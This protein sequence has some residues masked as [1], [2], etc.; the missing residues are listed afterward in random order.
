MNDVPIPDRPDRPNICVH[1][2]A[3]FRGRIV[4]PERPLPMTPHHPHA[5][6]ARMGVLVTL[7]AVALSVASCG[8]SMTTAPRPGSADRA[9]GGTSSPYPNSTQEYL[10]DVAV[11]PVAGADVHQLAT[12]YGA[13][14]APGSNYTC[15]RLQPPSG[16]SC[17]ELAAQLSAD[18]RVIAAERNGVI[19]TAETRQE[20]Y[21]SDD[22]LGSYETAN[23]QPAAQAVGLDAAHRVSGGDGVLVAVIDTGV[24]PTHPL[25][26]SRLV[27]G[28]DYVDYDNDPTDVPNGIDDDGDGLIDEAW[29][30][31]THVAGI[32]ALTAPGAHIMPV[33]VLNADGRGDIAAVAAGIRWAI[34]HGARVINLS[35]GMLQ[36]SVCIE[37]LL[38][39]AD[40]SG[41]I[42]V[43]SA[44]NSGM[45]LPHEYPASSSHALAIAASDA[46]ASPAPF[47]SFASFVA[48]SAPGV[49]VRS[50]YPGAAWRLW[51]GTSMSAPFVAG[52]V[53]LLLE[54]HPG[55]HRSEMLTRLA[56]TARPL[57]GVS[58]E[59][60]GKLGAGMLDGAAALAPDY[61]P[62]RAP[63][64]GGNEGDL[65]VLSRR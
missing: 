9:V 29:G 26:Q 20:S 23:E 43:C 17:E 40:Q 31:G 38:Q 6:V 18:P 55:W 14:I 47:T 19:E 32:V 48:I 41:V 57:V 34:D 36:T 25:L 22:G 49:S 21:A 39:V 8:R 64:Y 65:P 11:M 12:D 15:V 62:H 45:E 44:G 7:I 37:H 63:G 24:D 28:W 2:K 4:G 56:G 3:V 60:Q 54:K 59:Q 16:E 58:C 53:A 42:V 30:H 5:A 10:D 46:G 1:P 27:G 13:T 52:T 33:R 61:L 51:S 50:S 35:L